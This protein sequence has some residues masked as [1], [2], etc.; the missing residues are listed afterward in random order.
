[1]R[2][3]FEDEACSGKRDVRRTRLTSVARKA[4]AEEGQERSGK[5]ERE[6]NVKM[7]KTPVACKTSVSVLI[8]LLV[9]LVSVLFCFVLFYLFKDSFSG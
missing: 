1:V 2:G 7:I 3:R 6:R 9:D 5:M 4:Q 8:G